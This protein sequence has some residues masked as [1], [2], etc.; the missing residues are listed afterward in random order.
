ME[1]LGKELNWN[2]FINK[3]VPGPTIVYDNIRDK[4]LVEDLWKV[5]SE[6]DLE[7]RKKFEEFKV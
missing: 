6:D 7:E 3:D 5:Y 4:K 2:I 1:E